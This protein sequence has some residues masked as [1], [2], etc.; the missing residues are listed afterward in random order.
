MRLGYMILYV[1]SMIIQLYEKAFGFIH[2]SS[3]HGVAV[4]NGV[5]YQIAMNH[6][7]HQTNT[8]LVFLNEFG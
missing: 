7:T 6:I 2:D 5:S 3:D 1:A 4:P 8:K